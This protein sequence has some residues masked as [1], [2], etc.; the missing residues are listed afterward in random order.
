MT[1]KTRLSVSVT[2]IFILLSGWMT[3]C[4]DS[5]SP[6]DKL[7]CDT[8]LEQCGEGCCTAG[9]CVEGVC[10]DSTGECDPKCSE[11][12]TCANGEC[13]KACEGSQTW[14]SGGCY[15]TQSD[16]MHCGDCETAC[17]ET[18]SCQ[19]GKCEVGCANDFT[20]VDGKCFNTNL[21]SEHCGEKLANCS[22]NAF[23]NDG[24]C[25]C[26]KGY[27]D[28]DGDQSNGCE[29][30]V[31]C[32]EICEDGLTSCGSG[33][34]YDL[35]SDRAHC[36]TCTKACGATEKC[37]K[38]E[39]VD[40]TDADC[41]EGKKVC[42]GEC[43]D[44]LSDVKNCG[45]CENACKET[46]TCKAG[47]CELKCD[48]GLS[49]CS[50]KCVDLSKDIKNCGTCGNVCEPNQMCVENADGVMECRS[51]LDIDPEFDCNKDADPE[52][53]DYVE[54]TEC[55]GQC[56]DL[57]SDVKNC[58][59][60]GSECPDGWVCDEAVCRLKCEEGLVACSDACV[61]ITS[62]VKHCGGCD[63]ACAPNQKCE[64]NEETGI[65]SCVDLDQDCNEGAEEG[66]PE[67]T[68][69]WGTCT[70]LKTD[71][72]NC[73]V[74]GNVCD[75]NEICYEGSCLL[76][77]ECG[78]GKDMC[79]GVCTDLMNDVNNC[80]KCLNACGS[81]YECHLGSCRPDCGTLARCN[82]AC[83]DTQTSVHH[84]GGCGNECAAGQDCVGGTCQCAVGRDDCDGNAA[85]GCEST[86][87][88]HCE[89][90]TKRKCWHGLESNLTGHDENGLPTGVK[91]ACAL[92]EQTCNENGQFW[93]PC[94]GATYP[95]PITCDDTG[96]FIGNDQNCDG[97]PDE[98]QECKSQCDLMAGEMSYIGC[99]YWAVYTENEAQENHTVVFSNPSDKDNATVYIYNSEKL[100][101]TVTLAPKEVKSHTLT[102]GTDNMLKS[103]SVTN[104]SYRIRSNIPITAYQ[105]N[106][107]LAA[108]AHSND[109]SLMLP[110][111]VLGKDYRVM[112]WHVVPNNGSGEDFA[113]SVSI[114]ATE[115]GE[116]N[117]IV[118][119]TAAIVSG[120][121]VGQ[122]SIG[123]TTSFKLKQFQVLNLKSTT[124]KNDQT[125]SLINASQKVAVYSGTRCSIIPDADWA[126]DHLEE[127]LFP[128]QS[129]GKSYY[130]VRSYPRG[131]A[132]D[133]WKIL[134]HE[135][136]TTVTLPEVLIPEAYK[137][138][139]KI[140]LN[141]G[142][143]IT[144]ET[145][146]SFPISADKP[147]SV[148][149]FLTGK[150]HNNAQTGDPAFVLA[151]P[152]EQYR[153]DYAFL[154]PSTYEVNY[155]SITKPKGSIV[156]LDNT[157][158]NT[159]FTA[160]EGSDFEFGYVSLT[161]GAH[162]MTSDVGFGLVGYGFLGY[163][164]YG[165]PIGLDLKV[166]NTN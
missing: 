62:D 14:C 71:T 86:T 120:A 149:Q 95:S 160:L 159:T 108:D 106:P 74:C 158:V 56:Y 4:G 50:E 128:I 35:M 53:D 15:N 67:M 51:T 55:W 64:T 79:F 84:C 46:E 29:S 33:Q 166:L 153:N 89:P 152:Y 31:S 165:Y 130:A 12:Q 10:K 94:I 143:F 155:V 80:G 150:D 66:A 28:C 40:N 121:G 113:S 11:G 78:A 97:V 139:G 16:A 142:Q 138:E 164:S 105:F 73:G 90:G 111:N 49:L 52:A 129:W 141:A 61:D 148:G 38:G 70:N 23:C 104:N 82:E 145:T 100:L 57:S 162:V 98:Q 13:V 42:Y 157:E 87:G 96:A 18:E 48:E 132:G 43:I 19:N 17:K 75:E 45:N 2:G 107:W 26:I 68:N 144:F 123:Y 140:V 112:N 25:E 125:G 156:K 91:G 136:N 21:D 6:S 81:G 32:D 77:T 126:C 85:N 30:T 58:G 72:A 22:D 83:V 109:A 39:C 63:Q 137:S 3:G 99:E 114:V 37:E 133:F 54:K 41:G 92:G 117:V 69:C 131:N 134:A 118:K 60:C 8:G 122:M 110:K 27:H 93:N 119:T 34:C 9:K 135:N 147:I 59:S 163:T 76:Q 88:C 1:N 124:V 116:T 65:T 146:S 5:S 115:P 47:V 101:N 102:T 24:A 127:Q 7:E 151:V 20:L 103:S 161:P 44:I 36:G 154:V